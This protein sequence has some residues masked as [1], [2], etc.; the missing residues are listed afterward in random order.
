M[1]TEGNKNILRRIFKENKNEIKKKRKFQKLIRKK[2]FL[3]K[4]KL[5]K[6]FIKSFIMNL[7]G[8]CRDVCYVSGQEWQAIAILGEFCHKPNILRFRKSQLKAWMVRLV[9]FLFVTLPGSQLS[10][11]TSPQTTNKHSRESSSL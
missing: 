3:K 8:N 2:S 4:Q 9:S 1:R 11:S 10:L 5:E 6:C 7:A